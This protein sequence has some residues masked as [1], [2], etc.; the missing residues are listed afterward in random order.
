M[1]NIATATKRIDAVGRELN[2]LLEEAEAYIAPDRREDFARQ[3]ELMLLS[4]SIELIE[5]LSKEA[6]THSEENR[7]GAARRWHEL[8]AKSEALKRRLQ[9]LRPETPQD[10]EATLMW[11]S[12]RGGGGELEL[13][14]QIK[15]APP[16]S[17][18]T[19]DDLIDI[20]EQRITERLSAPQP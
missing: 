7:P 16:F 3:V 9:L 11:M 13:I 8:R 15:Q 18:E 1:G 14:R 10:F 2:D 19:I 5:G 17:S 6:R 20:A 4:S 12:E